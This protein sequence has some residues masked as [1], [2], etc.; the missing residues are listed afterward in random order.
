MEGVV[1]IA[2]DLIVHGKAVLKHDQNLHKL[3]GKLEEKNLTLNSECTF[4]IEHVIFFFLSMALSPLRRT[5]N[6]LRRQ[7]PPLHPQG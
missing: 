3:W 2:A 1:N 7:V 5:C 4:K 6:Q